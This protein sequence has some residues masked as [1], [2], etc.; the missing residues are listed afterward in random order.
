MHGFDDAHGLCHAIFPSEFLSYSSGL[1]VHGLIASRETDSGCQPFCGQ[2]FVWDG[3]WADTQSGG[4]LTP[5]KLI[6]VHGRNDRRRACAKTC[7]RCP[8]S[9]MMHDRSHAWKEP[10]VGDLAQGEDIIGHLCPAD[11]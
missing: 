6:A 1:L 5:E 11:A 10:V 7:R 4:A 2:V 9:P 3:R 8:S